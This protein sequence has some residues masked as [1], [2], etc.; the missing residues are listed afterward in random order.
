MVNE[1]LVC[2]FFFFFGNT[3]ESRLLKELLYLLRFK[4]LIGHPTKLAKPRIPINSYIT[5]GLLLLRKVFKSCL[6]ISSITTNVGCPCDTTPIN[7]TTWWQ[8]NAFIMDASCKN[9]IRSRI[10]AFSLTVFIATR[11]SGISAIS[12]A[13]PSYTIPK[14]PWPN[15]RT[16]SI[17]LRFNSHSSG[18]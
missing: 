17:L 12:C 5:S 7:L 9:S 18:I 8:L 3:W 15:S 6:P 11:S 4:L 16:N 10:L 14:E 1:A 13:I 2:H